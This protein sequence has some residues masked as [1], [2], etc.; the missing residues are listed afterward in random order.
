[1]T[2]VARPFGT[3]APTPAPTLSPMAL[4]RARDLTD[5]L[6][7]PPGDPL[8]DA[9]VALVRER[10]TS[11]L[12]EVVGA[13]ADTGGAV[14][15]TRVGA[16]DLA[17]AGGGDDTGR[18]N[19]A[20]NGEGGGGDGGGDRN[21]GGVPPS[22]CPS[23]PF[24]WTTRTARRK[25]GLAAVG[26]C[27]EGKA[28]SPADAVAM[29]TADPAGPTGPGPTGP[30]SCADWLGSLAQPARAMV[31]AEAITWATRLWTAIEWHRIRTSPTVGGP[32]RW[33]HWNGAIRVALRGRVDVRLPGRGGAQ[34]SMV[35]GSPAPAARSALCLAALVDVLARGAH[36]APS[37]VVG[38]WPDSGRAWVVPVDATTLGATV[39]H[40]LRVVADVAYAGPRPRS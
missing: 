3:G 19:D 16:F 27:A 28:A 26:I 31:Q 25:I 34:L 29:V 21:R 4:P 8:S 23:S 32:D 14:P 37:R 35:G 33:W 1:V 36:G 2:G 24:R 5:A 30:G 11:G 18:R 12:A 20:G 7:A 6:L 10:L 17:C 15:Y 22:R 13:A 38:W 9:T 39:D 40:V